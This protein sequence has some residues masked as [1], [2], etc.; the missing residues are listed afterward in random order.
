MLAPRW[1]FL[2]I[3]TECLMILNLPGAR[4]PAALAR[5]G[6]AKYDSLGGLIEVADRFRNGL[7]VVSALRNRF[8]EE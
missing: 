6:G 5:H 4:R 1:V 2:I 8:P 3:S 7:E